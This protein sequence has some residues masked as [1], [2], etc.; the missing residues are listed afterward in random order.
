MHRIGQVKNV[1]CVIF[2]ARDTHEERLL[3]LRRRA[4]QLTELLADPDALS[5][6]AADYVGGGGGG[7]GG[8][9]VAAARA[10]GVEAGAAEEVWE[11]GV[12]WRKA[13]AFHCSR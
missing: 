7:G 12:W 1:R 8:H 10:G 11:G 6:L 3:E 2:F 9:G 5:V 13:E 4:G